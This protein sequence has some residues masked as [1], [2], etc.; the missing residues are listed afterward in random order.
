MQVCVCMYV[1]TYYACDNYPNNCMG[2][3]VC[4]FVLQGADGSVMYIAAQGPLP[5]TVSDFW[6]MLWYHNIEV[7]LHG[8]MSAWGSGNET[9]F[10]VQIVLMACKLIEMAKVRHKWNRF[11]HCK[12]SLSL[13]LTLSRSLSLS[14][15]PKC[16]RYWPPLNKTVSFGPITVTTVSSSHYTHTHTIYYCVGSYSTEPLKEGGHS[17]DHIFLSGSDFIVCRFLRA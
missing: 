5:H 4:V 13:S 9:V 7:W 15:Q 14:S 1:C 11:S 12:I 6:R 3:C 2:Q 8:G 16:E 10:C 17:W